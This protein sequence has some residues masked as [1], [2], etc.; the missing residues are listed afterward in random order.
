VNPETVVLRADG[1]VSYDFRGDRIDLAT[2]QAIVAAAR[3]TMGDDVRPRPALVQ[4][5]RAV[6]D[7]A[8]RRYFSFSKDQRAL[9]SR[10]AL[11]AGNPVSRVIGNFFVG[12]NRPEIPT[13]LFG[14]EASAV[15][16]LLSDAP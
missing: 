1:I 3:L 7:Q 9:S 12:L 11:I 14:D 2:A 13:R 8:A 5:H 4:L 15:A 16:W 10:V 6:V